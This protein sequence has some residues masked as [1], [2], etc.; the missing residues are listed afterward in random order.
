MRILHGLSI[1]LEE[2]I[3]EFGKPSAIAVCDDERLVRK[4]KLKQLTLARNEFLR[5]GM[6][7]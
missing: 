6:T 7:M 5:S 1:I 4:K 3:D 2:I